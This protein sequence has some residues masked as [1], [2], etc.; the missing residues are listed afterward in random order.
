MSIQQISAQN[1]AKFRINYANGDSKGMEAS[2]IGFTK[3]VDKDQYSLTSGSSFDY[4]PDFDISKIKSITRDRDN[5][6]SALSGNSL[7]KE[8]RNNI[9]SGGNIDD[10]IELLKTNVNVDDAY[11]DSN[12][13]IFVHEKDDSVSTV[14]PTV[15]YEDPFNNNIASHSRGSANITRAWK[16]TGENGVVAVFN[17][18]SGMHSRQGQNGMIEDLM[19]LLNS[20]NYGIEYYECED[21]TQANLEKVLRNSR[22]NDAYKAILI[23]SH[24]FINNEKGLDNGYT[25]DPWI[26]LGESYTSEHGLKKAENERYRWYN[27]ESEYNATFSVNDIRVHK[28]CLLYLGACD[29]LKYYTAGRVKNPI[30]G[31]DGPNI[32]SQA[33][34]LMLFHRILNN[35]LSINDALKSTWGYDMVLFNESSK[36]A[37]V[38][39]DN[40]DGV[41]L[42]SNSDYSYFYPFDNNISEVYL[43]EPGYDK[44]FFRRGELI[45]LND[46]YNYHFKGNVKY[47]GEHPSKIWFWLLPVGKMG[48]GIKGKIK[49]NKDGSF[50]FNYKLPNDMEGMY[51]II[52]GEKEDFTKKELVNLSRCCT[53]V[54]SSKFK[55]NSANTLEIFTPESLS[56]TDENNSSVSALSLKKDDSKILYI[57]DDEDGPYVATSSDPN[58]AKVSIS[59][60]ILTIKALQSGSTIVTIG[61]EDGY[62]RSTIELS[63]EEGS[64]ESYIETFYINGV[65]FD[66]VKVE[67][68]DFILGYGNNEQSSSDIENRNVAHQ[69]TLSTY[70]IGKFEVTQKQWMAVIGENPSV[71]VGDNLPVNSVSWYDCIKFVDEIN[72]V[73]PVRF[74]LPTEAEWFYAAYGGKNNERSLYTNPNYINEVAWYTN[75]SDDTIHEVGLKKTNSLGMFD[76]FGNVSEW[77]YDWYGPY[78]ENAVVN[79][80]GPE[81]G[82]SR[83]VLGGSFRHG[84]FQCE[85]RYMDTPDSKPSLYGFRLAID[86]YK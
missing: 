35:R 33:H 50:D 13:N 82:I 66:F 46:C 9:V 8:I 14:I 68:G 49:I 22:E 28:N 12:Y 80:T 84:D 48:T 26:V 53:F 4:Q 19:S 85:Q 27:F 6:I 58:V 79:P 20:H 73:A 83:M 51:D 44:V 52:M 57:N 62:Y 24:G 60:A 77:C 1:I 7:N 72:K 5:Y 34:A 70:Y 75:N 59:G 78:P 40:L 86:N 29:A 64:K 42:P 71:F 43:E 69:V 23:F 81:T 76:M 17:Y 11:K 63:V 10:I 67:G 3:S 65:A 61:D 47:Y 45:D 36:V 37:Y 32:L 25:K 39:S 41:Y 56:I 30:I 18:F 38:V 21:F 16:E 15:D 2:T 55:E 31:W 54:Y 74:R